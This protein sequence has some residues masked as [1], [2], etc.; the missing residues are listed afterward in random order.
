MLTKRLDFN[1]TLLMLLLSLWIGGALDMYASSKP[2][3]GCSLMCS[4][5]I[6][7]VV[8]GDCEY[9]PRTGNRSKMIVAVFLEWTQAPFGSRIIVRLKGQ[10]QNFDPY[11]PGCPPYVQFIL[12]PDGSN[13]TITATFNVGNCTASPVNI[14]LPGPCDPPQCTGNQDIGGIVFSDFNNN[15]IREGSETG[16]P[17]VPISVYDDSKNLLGSTISG[18]AGLWALSGLAPGIKLRV[19]FN[20]GPDL[21]DS[22]P[23]L[24]NKTRTQKA[25]TGDC[26]VHL[27]VYQIQDVIEENPWIA[28]AMF[29]K[30]DA[31]NPSSPAYL[32]AAIVGNLYNTPDGGPRLGPNGNYI[33]ATA[34]ECG[35]IW[36]LG[37]QKD[38]R[39]LFSASFLKRNA[40]IGP[41]GLGA[42]YYTD[43]N[44]FLPVPPVVP[45]YNYFGNTQLLLNLDDYGIPTGDESLLRRNLPFNLTD[46]SH[47]SIVYGLVGKWGLADLDLN[48]TGDML[49][50]VNMYNQSLIE[51]QLGNPLMLPL[52]SSRVREY[53]IPNPNCSDAS[54]WRPWGLKTHRGKLYVG[55][56]CSAESTQRSSDLQAVIYEFE[57][58][59]FTEFLRFQLN[60]QKGFVNGNYCGTFRPWSNNF[61][62]YFVG[63]DVACGPV[64]V[65]SDMEFDSEGNLIVSLGD[66]FGY[67]TGGRD[68]GTRSNDRLAY[69]V[70][71]G[72]DLLKFFK[73]KSDFLLEKN[74]TA[75]FYTTPG[76][77]NAQGVCG[78][79]YYYQDGYYGHQE[80]V[81]GALAIHPSYNT[82]LATMMDPAN[83]WSN[84][85]SQIDNSR[86]EK[87]VNYNIFTGEKGTFGKSSGLGDIELLNGSSTPQG[88]GVSIGNYIWEDQDEDGLQD[89][90]EPGMDSISVLLLDSIGT[91]LSKT[92]TDAEGLY[93]FKSLIPNHKYWIQLGEDSSYY[94]KLLVSKS[95]AFFATTLHNRKN[96]GNKENDSDAARLRKPPLRIEDRIL[97]EYVTGDEGQNDFSLD[98]GLIPCSHTKT[99]TLSINLCPSDSLLV[100][101]QWFFAN[102][103][104]ALVV[105]PEAS[106]RGCDSSLWIQVRARTTG[107]FRLDTAICEGAY[108]EIHQT[109]FD[110]NHRAGQIQL[111]GAGQ[112]GCDSILDVQLHFL[113]PGFSDYQT[114]TCKNQDL[115]IHGKVFNSSNPTDTVVLAGANQYGC[116]STILI[117]VDFYDD[118]YSILQPLVCPSEKIQIHGKTFD[119][120]HPSDTVLL[121]RANHHGCDSIIDIRLQFKSNSSFALDT[122]I[123]RSD[124]IVI[125]NR[126][127][128]FF[129][130]RDTIVLLHANGQDCDSTIYFQLHFF[131]ESEGTLDQTI[132]P[133]SA[134]NIHGQTLDSN[135]TQAEIR[136]PHAD[137]NGCD[138]MLTARVQFR[139]VNRSSL[140]SSICPGE[141]LFIHNEW[142]NA[143]RTRADIILP[144]ADQYGCD[145]IVQFQLLF[146]PEYRWTDTAEACARFTWPVNGHIYTQSGTYQWQGTTHEGCDSAHQLFLTIFPEYTF[147]DSFCTIDQYHWNISGKPYFE[148]GIYEKLLSSE[149]GCDSLRILVLEIIGSGEVYVPNVFSPNGDGVN[150]F[151]TVFANPDVKMIDQFLIFDRWGELMYEL[152]NFQANNT[153]QGWDGNHRGEAVRPAVFAYLV[154]WTDKL[155][156]NHRQY[157]DIT[158][159]R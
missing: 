58:G 57:N 159:I 18:T 155:G 77:N 48:E 74:A 145:S 134:I 44:N 22:N 25:S 23:G 75:G 9:G 79:E 40:S 55:G 16:L 78:G 107:M 56:V 148:S 121:R 136:L 151:T 123:C 60:Y 35:S 12:D 21:Y 144:K 29:S 1:P 157:G 52:D 112:Y 38:S 111:D 101:S 135:R 3:A 94:G 53:P 114:F 13:Q 5:T 31:S 68:F 105:F 149:H 103:P 118:G 142:F 64:P 83:I 87:K 132:C 139:S 88:I 150:D 138:S 89:P 117:K 14:V 116:D 37:F 45:G 43:L 59:K 124:S 34:G 127:Y 67:Q 96:F 102:S 97:L 71:S 76:M 131:P 100:G 95:R 32:Q 65:L 11:V 140:D 154:E 86:G 153:Q 7:K 81:Q 85:W 27:G 70:F 156:G 26:Q 20:P 130:S 82:V 73:L 8:I 125:W 63:G 50:T 69:L 93:Y 99:D 51:I 4:L 133:G 137:I 90:G 98:F 128:S 24:D 72:G 143:S 113:K 47:D 17:G 54:D 158:L 10:T 15:G 80:S 115:S 62:N 152:K 92:I 46:G 2:D 6:K 19:E 109:R 122:T 41:H 147:V 106:F 146:R 129:K 66:R 42:I 120:N 49:Y 104:D 39:L 91:I 141:S 30:G 28:T 110:A 61:Y 108:L 36:G 33:L 119:Q 126:T 84:G